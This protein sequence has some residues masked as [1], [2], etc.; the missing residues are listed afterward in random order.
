MLNHGRGFAFSEA[1]RY[2]LSYSCVIEQAVLLFLCMAKYSL[3]N[4]LKSSPKKSGTNHEESV[5]G[6]R[7]I[8]RWEWR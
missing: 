3:I 7:K 1:S 2:S 8:G 5:S 4:R 6:I